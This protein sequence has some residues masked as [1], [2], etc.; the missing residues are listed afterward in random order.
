MTQNKV[1]KIAG[2]KVIEELKDNEEKYKIHTR[3]GD[4][5]KKLIIGS[6]TSFEGSSIKTE[7]IEIYGRIESNIKSDIVYV[8]VA[9]EVFGSVIC[10][11]IEVHGKVNG[12]IDANGKASIKKSAQIIGTIR[13]QA[14]SIE[15]GATVYADLHC[16]KVDQA[17]LDKVSKL[18]KL[19]IDKKNAVGLNIVSS[20]ESQS[21]DIK[22][23]IQDIEEK[24]K[25]K[26]SFFS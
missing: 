7:N 13:Y 25:K 19:I 4:Y 14:V 24:P 26:S 20:D 9:A 3:S 12:S 17:Q 22:E 5:P 18:K 10:N 6:G 23:N 11:Q 2:G 16:T 8:G 1:D 21:S 15:E